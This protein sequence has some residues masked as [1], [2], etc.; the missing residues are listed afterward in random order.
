MDWEASEK[1]IWW[2]MKS[3]QCSYRR[4]T[5][6][7]TLS[8]FAHRAR[9]QRGSPIWRSFRYWKYHNCKMSNV[10][11][12]QQIGEF[13]SNQHQPWIFLQ[14]TKTAL[15]LLLSIHSMNRRKVLEGKNIERDEKRSPQ[16]SP[17]ANWKKKKV[18]I[19]KYLSENLFYYLTEN[20]RMS[21]ESYFNTTFTRF[22]FFFNAKSLSREI[23]PMVLRGYSSL[24]NVV[25]YH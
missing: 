24:T 23:Q 25:W 15:V 6:K 5:G 3:L 22:F 11:Y 9:S 4:K 16:P 12:S 14:F 18:S 19:R 20:L 17:Q 10:I 21:F 7:R 2:S 8:M 1:L 13:D